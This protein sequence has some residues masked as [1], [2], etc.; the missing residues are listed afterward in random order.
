MKLGVFWKFILSRLL[1]V[2]SY[3]PDNMTLFLLVD[4]YECTVLW[5]EHWNIPEAPSIVDNVHRPSVG[6][7]ELLYRPEEQRPW[8]N[9]A[10]GTNEQNVPVGGGAKGRLRILRPEIWHGLPLPCPSRWC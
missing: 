9:N 10:F 8:K 4:S 5:A 2:S 3:D 7:S 6:V 1:L